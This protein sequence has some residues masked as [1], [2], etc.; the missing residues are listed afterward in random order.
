MAQ[1]RFRTLKI[2]WHGSYAVPLPYNKFSATWSFAVPLPYK[3][4]DFTSRSSASAQRIF[5]DL[6]FRS[7]ASAQG[8]YY[9]S[10]FSS[11]AFAQGTIC[12]LKFRSFCTIYCDLNFRTS[13]SARKDVI[14][15]SAL[16]LLHEN[17]A[18]LWKIHSHSSTHPFLNFRAVLHE[19]WTLWRTEKQRNR[20][21]PGQS[22][23]KR[24]A[25]R[26]ISWWHIMFILAE[27]AI[28]RPGGF[29]LWPRERGSFIMLTHLRQR[30]W[31]A[32]VS[33]RC[34]G[35]SASTIHNRLRKK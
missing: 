11:S 15:N 8:T 24:L 2:L 27:F 22:R 17:I 16:L 9:V 26:G 33:A 19:W 13:A 31:T 32:T 18:F 5:C 21:A 34:Y 30:F 10:K 7:F 29:A 4:F 35:L 23:R 14:W 25:A 3:S 20:D 12:D 6:K 28:E 1:F